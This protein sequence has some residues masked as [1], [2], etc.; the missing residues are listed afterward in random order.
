MA[1]RECILVDA[2]NK[3][4]PLGKVM[5]GVQ[6]EDFAAR[7]ECLLWTAQIPKRANGKV[8]DRE[9]PKIRKFYTQRSRG[10]SKTSDIA[11][12][13]IWLLM[14]CNYKID[15]LIVAE[16]LEQAQLVIGQAGK[17]VDANPWLM[18]FIDVQKK[19]LV[20]KVTKGLFKCL[21]SDLGSSLG[22][23]PDVVI[24]DEWSAWSDS[25]WWDSIFSS[26]GKKDKMLI[27]GCNALATGSWQIAKRELFKNEPD[28]YCSI[29][30]GYA[31][32]FTEETIHAQRVG[33][34]YAEF[35][36]LW[37]NV[38][39]DVGSVFIEEHQVAACRNELLQREDNGSD[40]IPFYVVAVDYAERIDR[41]VITVS[42]LYDGVVVV[43]RMDVIDPRL[44]DGVV[45]VSEVLELLDSIDI[46]FGLQSE[47]AYVFDKHQM[48][49]CC[50]ILKSAGK[51]VE[52]FEFRSGIG[53]H[54]ASILLQ[55]YLMEQKVS[56]YP[57]CGEMYDADGNIWM[58]QDMPDNL[59]TELCDLII[60]DIPGSKRW[61]F[62]HPRGGHDDRAFT[63]AA[64][65]KFFH[66]RLMEEAESDTYESEEL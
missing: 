40:H 25:K 9:K 1:F 50:Q 43:D 29:P 45:L 2:G 51:Y 49:H 18:Q 46:Q 15:G 65:I 53:N 6:R 8:I 62:D 36:R 3:L 7:D 66:D 41:T 27:V 52:E 22:L 33:I 34:D 11:L 20:S 10:Y 55:Q 31:P 59:E 16:D 57:G 61:R 30:Y 63:I 47:V 37:M 44:R 26:S 38:D 17:I 19:A 56:W 39:S 21:S 54:Q 23:S 4:Q 42:H 64:T 24:A 48:A 60:K 12:D 35:Q 32:W 28:W 13:V 5:S 14:F 58:P